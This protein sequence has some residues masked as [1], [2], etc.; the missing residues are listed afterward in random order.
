MN[1]IIADHWYKES[2][3]LP[4]IDC[5]V[6][7]SGEVIIL[8]CISLLDTST[9][10]RQQIFCHP[11]CDTTIASLEKY[12]ACD[13]T[14]VD[15]WVR[16]EYDGG[17]LIGGD[18][19]MGNE[20]FIAHVNSEGDLIW[21]IFFWVTNPIRS[22]AINNGILSAVNEHSDLRIDINLANLTDITMTII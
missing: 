15:E 13:W 4:G 18:G 1:Q 14:I 8:S 7:A 12:D 2:P 20:G 3:E 11:C 5:I 10:E 16:I 17:S 21:G 22:L 9:K 19:T 6:Y